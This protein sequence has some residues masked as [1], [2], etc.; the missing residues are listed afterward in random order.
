[1]KIVCR[2]GAQGKLYGALIIRGSNSCYLD[3]PLGL[4]SLLH[5]PS[6]LLKLQPSHL[7]SVLGTRKYRHVYY[8]FFKETFQQP[9]RVTQLTSHWPNLSGWLHLT[10]RW[11]GKFN[12]LGGCHYI[13]LKSGFQKRNRNIKKK[14]AGSVNLSQMGTSALSDCALGSPTELKG[15]LSCNLCQLCLYKTV[16]TV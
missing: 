2:C 15:Q 6:W 3:S 5:G 13:Q 11:P 8:F 10:P 7:N 16:T 9:H 12:P 4:M 1:M 14:L